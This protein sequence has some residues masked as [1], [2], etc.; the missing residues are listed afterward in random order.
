MRV[1]PYDEPL[2]LRVFV[3]GSVIEVF[4]NE[5]HCLTSRVYPTDEDATGITLGAVGGRVEIPTLDAWELD[6]VW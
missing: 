6:S 5:R 4:A 3:D 2:D 1:S